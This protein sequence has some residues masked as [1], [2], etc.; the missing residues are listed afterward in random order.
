MKKLMRFAMAGLMLT[1]LVG[2]TGTARASDDQE[3]VLRGDCSQA[4]DWKLRI[5]TD[6]PD[7][8]DLEW[9][10]GEVPNQ[11]WRV[12]MTYNGTRVFNGTAI[13]GADGEFDVDREVDNQA[14]T[15]TLTGLARN[16]VTGET[17]TG[18]LSVDL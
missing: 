6:G 1:G 11:T 12:R 16:T 4:S 9:E 7:R 3:V 17:C 5:R 13:S 18:T 8:L 15:D 14:G 10:A 2:V